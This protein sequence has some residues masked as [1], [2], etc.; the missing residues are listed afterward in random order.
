M[1]NFFGGLLG[2]PVGRP[3]IEWPERDVRRQSFAI[4]WNYTTW[5]LGSGAETL[6]RILLHLLRPAENENLNMNLIFKLLSRI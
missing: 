6:P 3:G 1:G 5:H 2:D 4:G